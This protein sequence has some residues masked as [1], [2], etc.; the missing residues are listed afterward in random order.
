MNNN[1]IFKKLRIA[2]NMKDTDIIE[3]LNLVNFSISKS[4]I[5]ALFR[6][7]DHRNFKKCGDQLLRNFLDGIIKKERKQ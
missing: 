2:F 4:E 1:D 3:T 6:N 7:K 5:N